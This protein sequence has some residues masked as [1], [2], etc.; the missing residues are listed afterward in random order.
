MDLPANYIT[1]TV[2]ACMPSLPVQVVERIRAGDG[3]QKK[4]LVIDLQTEKEMAERVRNSIQVVANC[5]SSVLTW[6]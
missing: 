5:I 3:K 2:C 4:I 6:S 1:F